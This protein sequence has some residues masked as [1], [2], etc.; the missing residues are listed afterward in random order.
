MNQIAW[1]ALLLLLLTYFVMGWHLS[2]VH[3]PLHI[4]LL[5]AL[6]IVLLAILLT[7]PASTIKQPI[8]K[9]FQSDLGVFILVIFSSLFI[10]IV[11]TLKGTFTTL[12]LIL[13]STIL[14]RVE[15]RN[16]GR[17]IWQVL[18]ILILLPL[19]GLGLGVKLDVI[20]HQLPI[21]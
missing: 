2:V 19:L 7:T 1:I 6:G 11:A 9:L 20:I 13:A 8:L 17:T 3:L 16:A 5:I 14:A 10:V 4:W 12:M 21:F 15:L 18:P